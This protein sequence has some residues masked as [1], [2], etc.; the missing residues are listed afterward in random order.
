[1]MQTTM[2]RI[3][4]G[5]VL[6][7]LVLGLRISSAQYPAGEA[8][9]VGLDEYRGL[10]LS[11]SSGLS[12]THPR[13]TRSPAEQPPQSASDALY[14][15][16]CGCGV[17]DVGTSA[18]LPQGAGGTIWLEYDYQNQHKNRRGSSGAPESENNDKAIR[19]D[20]ITFGLQYMFNRAWGLQVQV[21]VDHR[22]FKSIDDGGNLAS[23]TWTALGDIRVKGLY[24]GF[25]DDQSLGIDCGVKLP[26][27]DYRHD[28]A[29][30]DTQIGTGSTDILIG[31]Y[32]RTHLT[33][34]QKWDAYFQVEAD[35][36]V[37]IS[38]AYRPGIEVDGSAGISYTGFW[39]HGVNIIPIGQVIVSGRTS[40]S[41]ANSANPVASGYERVLLSP[42]LELHVHPF[43]IY[44]DVEF[45]VYQHVTGD[46]ITAPMLFKF[47][48]SYNF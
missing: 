35:I 4:C 16:A 12:D 44:A 26:T 24:T 28:G 23:T 37:L 11:P 21:P 27:G 10:S 38:D 46:Q 1:M 14:A 48:V 31:G 47:I 45:P 20:Y 43:M 7:V 5:A 41:G 34:D 29:D 39:F 40:D 3:S 17:F 32:Y 19:T 13:S 9:T 36:P 2:L 42:G 18:M 33:A 6:S 22:Y 30:R 15:C 8:S 25:F